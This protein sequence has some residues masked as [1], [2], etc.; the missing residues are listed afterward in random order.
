M[1]GSGP[2]H[3]DHGGGAVGQL[4]GVPGG[5][6][7]VGG[8]GRAQLGQ[9]LGG[10]AGAD[11]LVLGHQQRVA[12][13]LRH[14]HGAISSSNNP[15]LR[16]AVARSWLMR[17]VVVLLGAGEVLGGAVDVGGGAHSAVVERAEQGVVRGG[18]DEGGVAVAVAC[19][20]F[21]QQVGAVGHRLHAARDHGVELAV[22]DQLVGHGDRVQPGQADLVHRQRGHAHGDAAVDRGLSGGD[23]PGARLDDVTHDDVVDL[24]AGDTCFVQCRGDGDATQI[25]RGEV[26]QRARQ[27]A[28]RRPRAPD[29]DRAWHGV[30][31]Y[32]IDLVA[33]ARRNIRRSTALGYLPQTVGSPAC[34][35]LPP[36]LWFRASR[37]ETAPGGTGKG[38]MRARLITNADN[39]PRIAISPPSRVAASRA[40]RTAC[41][42]RRRGR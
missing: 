20:G 24:V 11:A 32:R 27:F 35:I 9:A 15:Y 3:H 4:R 8:E 37:Q 17:G 18:V 39:T 34:R 16:A 13:A 21:L 14:G 33:T 38:R 6:R 25:H 10:G 30:A 2:A 40:A 1:F 22:A 19:A 29:D 5:H 26:L 41:G 23:L 7:A 12:F 28:D 31:P 42:R 36:P